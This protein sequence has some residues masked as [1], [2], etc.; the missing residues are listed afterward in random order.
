[1]KYFIGI[2]VA[3][4]VASAFS[5][6]YTYFNK[7]PLHDGWYLVFL[8]CSI[9][10]LIVLWLGGLVCLSK[11]IEFFHH[12]P[13]TAVGILA[14]PL[15]LSLIF[16]MSNLQGIHYYHTK[17]RLEEKVLIELP[18]S[19]ANIDEREIVNIINTNL[20][21]TNC[22]YFDLV[23]SIQYSK[24]IDERNILTTIKDFIDSRSLLPTQVLACKLHN[25]YI[26]EMYS[27]NLCNRDSLRSE[28]LSLYKKLGPDNIFKVYYDFW[29][30]SSRRYTIA[31]SKEEEYDLAEGSTRTVQMYARRPLTLLQAVSNSNL[32]NSA[33]KKVAKY[34]ILDYMKQYAVEH[35]YSPDAIK[36]F[37][38]KTIN[39]I[40]SSLA[41]ELEDGVYEL[42]TSK[43][44]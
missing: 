19:I 7:I 14:F 18:P 20:K 13:N 27:D 39:R 24:N 40:N 30:I 9:I 15:L 32:F 23:W 31:A 28:A 21:K 29:Y 41:R 22:F 33:E 5:Y 1:M 11:I 34:N 3:L 38:D 35:N 8:C 25:L 37:V 4:F 17:K 2:V 16:M 36:I 6:L 12:K 42:Y 44:N 10:P 26:T 43:S